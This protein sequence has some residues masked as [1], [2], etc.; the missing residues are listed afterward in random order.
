MWFRFWRTGGW[1][2]AAGVVIGLLASACGTLNQTL[3]PHPG[4]IHSVHVVGG[5]G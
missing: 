2:L 3:V 1:V 4:D 5:S